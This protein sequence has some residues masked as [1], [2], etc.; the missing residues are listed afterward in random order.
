MINMLRVNY[1][2]INLFLE[3]QSICNVTCPAGGLF[4][5]KEGKTGTKLTC[6]C[7]K[8]TGKCKWKNSSNKK[9]TFEKIESYFCSGGD[10]T[11][12]ELKYDSYLVTQ[13][14]FQYL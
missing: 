7:S 5:G 6:K 3:N 2:S 11:G 12:S 13:T 1:S 10:D 4:N 14:R 9:V 8:K